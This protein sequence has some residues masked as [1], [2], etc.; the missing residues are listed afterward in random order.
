MHHAPADGKFCDEYGNTLKSAI[1][2][3]ITDTWDT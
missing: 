2:K 3:T 1:V